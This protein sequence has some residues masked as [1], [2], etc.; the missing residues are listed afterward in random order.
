MEQT[1]RRAYEMIFHQPP[2]PLA[3]WEI[4]SRLMEGLDETV[5]GAVCAKTVILHS[6]LDVSYPDQ[7]TKA[8]VFYL[9]SMEARKFWQI[10]GEPTI[11]H[12]ESVRYRE[13]TA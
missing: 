4:A 3:M 12:F 1:L 10:S 11:D 5:L 9:A 6:V 2:G 7:A 8:S 13:Q